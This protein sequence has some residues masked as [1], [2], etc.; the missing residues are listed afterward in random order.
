MY[1]HRFAQ[2]H[3]RNGAWRCTGPCFVSNGMQHDTVAVHTFQ[4]KAIEQVK[5]TAPHTTEDKYVGDR[6]A[7]QQAYK[8][9][10][11]NF[12]N[13]TVERQLNDIFLQL[14]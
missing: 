4:D 7:G 10:S 8:K 14:P 9:N 6:A 2:C 1:S 5:T 12:S 13:G 11:R 3:N